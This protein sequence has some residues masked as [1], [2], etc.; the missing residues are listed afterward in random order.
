MQ[1][2]ID[3][4]VENLISFME[5]D[6]TDEVLIGDAYVTGEYAFVNTG[7]ARRYVSRNVS[8]FTT[9]ATE[10]VLHRADRFV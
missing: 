9:T 6:V 4:L 10:D 2:D 8:T 5:N 1:V 7:E 3:L